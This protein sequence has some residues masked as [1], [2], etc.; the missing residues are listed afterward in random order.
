[1]RA[2]FRPAMKDPHTQRPF[3]SGHPLL[4]SPLS[5]SFILSLPP[6]K[7]S[8][9]DEGGNKPSA[10]EKLTFVFYDCDV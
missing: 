4:S 5:I 8:Y 7:R 9:C 6:I 2:L 1:M 3:W 10:I